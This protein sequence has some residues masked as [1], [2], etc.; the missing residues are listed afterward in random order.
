QENN[1]EINWKTGTIKWRNEKTE[2]NPQTL[3]PDT[4]TE[5]RSLQ[6]SIEEIEDEEEHLNHT[7][8]P[9]VEMEENST[10]NGKWIKWTKE[11]A[12]ELP[13]FSFDL[14]EI[15]DLDEEDIEE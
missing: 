14:L 5:I 1:P 15:E 9:T 3:V 10:D 13:I 7:Q 6:P 2:I 12:Q 8:N 11:L 4:Q